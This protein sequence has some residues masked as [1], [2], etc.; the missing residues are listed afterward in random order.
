M[1]S[2]S[3]L[4]RRNCEHL[5]EIIASSNSDHSVWRVDSPE[6]GLS[7]IGGLNNEFLIIK[8]CQHSPE[9][10]GP[11]RRP[12][13]LIS[14]HPRFNIEAITLQIVVN[15][16]YLWL[17]CSIG[18]NSEALW[19]IADHD[20]IEHRVVNQICEESEFGILILE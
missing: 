2:L 7:V 6:R 13:L 20:H 11:H 14:E 8:V 3:F 18:R 10:S 4:K 5:Y 12:N 17:S 15:G 16:R 1:L 9:T 19:V